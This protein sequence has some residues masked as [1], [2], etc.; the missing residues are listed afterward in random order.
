VGVEKALTYSC[1]ILEGNISS[2]KLGCGKMG[3]MFNTFHFAAFSCAYRLP[4]EFTA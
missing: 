1:T 2:K 3:Q 4:E